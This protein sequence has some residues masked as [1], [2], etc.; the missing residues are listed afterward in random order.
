MSEHWKS[1]PRY[2]CKYCACFV[3]DTKL[4]RQNHEA[5]ARHQG[6]LKRSLRNLHHAHERE[7]RDKERAQ[8]EIARLSGVVSKGGPPRAATR[9]ARPVP[10][11]PSESELQR[12]REQ[13]AELGVAVPSSFR[14]AMAIPCEWTV[15]SSR[16]I[17]TG[18]G[19]AGSR[20]E[21]VATGVRKRDEAADE[22][23]DEDEALA[24]LFKKPRRWGRDSK[25]MAE[26]EDPELDAML[27]VT[28]IPL[29]RRPSDEDGLARQ[30]TD[31]AEVQAKTQATSGDGTRVK[32]E[33]DDDEDDDDPGV[34]A[35]TARR[36]AIK[37]EADA[38]GDDTTVTGPWQDPAI[39]AEE[40]EGETAPVVFKKRKAKGIR[41]K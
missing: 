32:K 12:Q 29:K 22:R 5:T 37:E 36:A 27:S 34:G 24:R 39:K 7:Q 30:E 10:T 28:T 6:A 13:L 31:D 3:R 18:E 16:F 21:A 17:S 14:P 9:P 23:R 4:E 41:R 38:A 19:G 1:T 25:T 8:Q 33:E 2:W 20:P 35:A 15:T 40:A 26:G 11:A